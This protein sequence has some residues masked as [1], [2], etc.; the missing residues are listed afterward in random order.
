MEVFYSRF[1]PIENGKNYK[2]GG[3]IIPNNESESPIIALHVVKP[4]VG[5]VTIYNFTGEQTIFPATA[6]VAGGIYNY[7]TTR[8][9]YSDPIDDKAFF[10]CRFTY[11]PHQKL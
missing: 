11:K 2:I 10:G 6:F 4:L 9:D 5:S 3:P 7:P 8:V 1:I